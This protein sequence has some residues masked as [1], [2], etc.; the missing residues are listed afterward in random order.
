MIEL[1]AERGY[2]AV[3][4]RELVRMAGVATGTFYEHFTDKD[5]CFLRTYG[6]IVRRSMKQVGAAQKDC[7]DWRERLRLA[8][9]AWADGIAREPQAARLALVEAFAGGP[10]A[11]EQMRRAEAHYETMIEQ[12]F[13]GAPDPVRFRR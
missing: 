13:A 5:E 11:L 1:V 10:A 2:G 3:T 12:S 6:L 8:F 9:C 4:V 7:H